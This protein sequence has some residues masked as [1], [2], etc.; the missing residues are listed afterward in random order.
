MY[1]SNFFWQSLLAALVSFASSIAAFASDP[2]IEWH[3]IETEHFEIL[4]DSRHYPLAKEFARY[5]ESAWLTLVPILR[6]WPEKT[7]V[8]LDDSTDLANGAAT[9]FPYPTIH[10]FPAVPDPAETIADTGPWNLELITHEYAHVLNFQPAHGVFSPLRWLFGSIVRPNLLLPR[11][12]LEGLAVEIETRYSPSGG[13]LRSPDFT[14]IPRAL[15]QDSLLRRENIARINEVSIPDWLGGSRPYLLGGLM[16]DS[17]ARRDLSIIGEFNDRYARRMPFFIEEPLRERLGMDWQGLLDSVYGDIEARAAQQIEVLCEFGCQEG[18]KLGEDSLFSRSPV[19]APDSSRL[20][21]LTREHNREA[22]LNV[23][24]REGAPAGKTVGPFAATGKPEAATDIPGASRI[25]WLP[26]SSGLISDGVDSFGPHQARADLWH[27]DREKK[28]RTRLTR[29]LRAREPDVAAD[30]RHVVYVQ[31]QPGRSSLAWSPMERK[32]DGSRRIA[33]G[34]TLYRPKGDNRVSWPSF[35]GPGTIVFAERSSDGREGLRTLNLKSREVR[36]LKVAGKFPRFIASQ[37]ALLFSSSRNGVTNLYYAKFRDD[38]SLESPRPWTNSTTRAWIGDIDT[39][40]GDTLIYSRLDGDGVHLRRLPPE[41]RKQN[42]TVNRGELASVPPLIEWDGPAYVPPEP[43]FAP[44]TLDAHDFDPWPYML[45]RYW[46]PYAAIVPEGVYLSASTS[47]GDPVGRHLA[48]A[49]L[50]TDTRIGK[51]NVFAAYSNSTTPVRITAMVDDF[52]QRLS[53]SGLDRRTT[54]SDASGLFYLPSPSANWAGEVGVSHQRAE[55]AA[56]GGGVDVRIRGGPRVGILWQ[57]LSQRGREISPEKGGSF[58]LAHTQYMPEMGNAVY[59]KSDLL[60]DGYFSRQSH[61]KIL[62]WLPDR[63]VLHTS[64][65]VIW[66][67]G[68]DRLLLGPSSLSLPIENIALGATSSTFVMR[69]YPTGSFLA[70]KLARGSLEYR[71]PLTDSYHGFDTSP[72]F[73]RR[74]HGAI[75][76]DALTIEGAYY[77]YARALYRTTDFGNMF[78]AVGLEARLDSTLF[79]H[80]PV[81]F[82]FGVHYGF[83]SRISPNGAYPVISISL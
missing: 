31:L 71:F 20:A 75:F 14:A 34:E 5:A 17:L 56:S 15:V 27:F 63:H 13:R 77:D 82:I 79:Y 66:A 52:W 33:D 3:K 4:Y 41:T 24:A 73:I 81:Q 50:S 28:K 65:G 11:W 72:A 36:D 47:S 74:W 29:G 9:G 68:L 44:G 23:V 69:G 18:D 37:N 46:M 1:R 80:V 26:D 76:V 30:G 22:I 38:G 58:K 49:A 6:T 35:I 61:P 53:S 51:P 21:F 32:P 8:V 64:A 67:P 2:T 83:D 57:D 48:A 19:I 42:E 54:T 59:E 16:W 25:S 60:A 62:G 12:Y 78:G 39:K 55:L 43:Q 10:L 7:V 40:T 45:P 70:R